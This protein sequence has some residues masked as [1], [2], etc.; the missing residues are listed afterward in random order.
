MEKMKADNIL[1]ILHKSFKNRRKNATFNFPMKNSGSTFGRKAEWMENQQKYFSR[2][3]D[4]RK[5]LLS[6]NVSQNEAATN[7][8]KKK[9]G[10]FW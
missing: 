8:L 1:T 2:D 10:D 6:L 9:H 3:M 5:N 4:D 7:S